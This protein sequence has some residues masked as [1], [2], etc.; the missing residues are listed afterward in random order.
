MSSLSKIFHRLV[1]TDK[2][3]SEADI[4]AEVRQFILSAPFQLDDEDLEDVKLESPLGDRRRIDVEVGATV[5]EVKRDLGPKKVKLDAIE[6]LK[7]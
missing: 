6:Q 3:R 5:I 1:E 4:Q 7:G 2:R